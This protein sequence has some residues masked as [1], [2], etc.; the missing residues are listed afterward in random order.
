MERSEN[1]L[2]RTQATLCGLLLIAAVT[3]VAY[4]SDCRA[5]LNAAL[6]DRRPVPTICGR[7]TSANLPAEARRVALL[8]TKAAT[9]P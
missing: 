5:R 6:P 1:P 7:A 9:K 3:Y 4:L 2:S 8:A